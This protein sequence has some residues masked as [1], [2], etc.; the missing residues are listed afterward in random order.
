MSTFLQICKNVSREC[1]I[2]GGD[3]VPTAVTTQTGELQRV[4]KWVEQAYKELQEKYLDWR[5]MRVGFTVNTVSGTDSYAYG[6]VTDILTSA[7]ITRFSRWRLFDENDPPKIYLT[8][9]GVGTEGWLIPLGWD[10]FKWLYR[11]GTQ[12]NGYPAHITID[13]QNN[14]VL[15]PKPDGIYTVTGD[16]QRSAQILAA[17]GDIPEMPTQYHDLIMYLAMEKY[18][19]FHS[20]QEVLVAA[21]TGIGRILGQLEMNQL[22]PMPLAGPMA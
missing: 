10:N 6:T 15:G 3:T 21:R 18:A 19:L 7:V 14:I 4:V 22:P 1:N 17:D 8:A 11:K 9:S 13:P 20:A 16:Y 5:W 2:S 12:N